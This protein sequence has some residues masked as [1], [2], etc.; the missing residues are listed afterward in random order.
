MKIAVAAQQPIAMPAMPPD[1]TET[2]DE[3]LPLEA[4]VEE[5]PMVGE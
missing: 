1:D 3:L 4:A 5:G 2:V